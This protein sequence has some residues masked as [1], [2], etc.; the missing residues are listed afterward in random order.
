MKDHKYLDYV[1]GFDCFFCGGSAPNTAHHVRCHTGGGMKPPD[2]CTV[3]L[4]YECHS[5][6]H[7][8]PKT[9][10]MTISKNDMGLE[11]IRL[12]SQYPILKDSDYLEYIESQDCLFCGKRDS[13][14][15]F[16]NGH[17][18]CYTALPLC[19]EHYDFYD[20]DPVAFM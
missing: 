19:S 15:Y 14:V 16:G 1:R 3:S 18:S 2:V 12:I 13:D 11:V 20:D 7:R 9:F 10:Y 17:T 6:V 5:L 4:C 8:D